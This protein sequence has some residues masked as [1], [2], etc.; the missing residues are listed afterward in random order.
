MLSMLVL[1]AG[2]QFRLLVTTADY[3]VNGDSRLETS[4]HLDVYCRRACDYVF[5]ISEFGIFGRQFVCKVLGIGSFKPTPLEFGRIHCRG[6]QVSRSSTF[7]VI[8]PATSRMFADLTCRDGP[9]K[10]ERSATSQFTPDKNPEAGLYVS[11]LEFVA[12]GLYI[13]GGVCP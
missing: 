12:A 8:T 10:A 5:S 7:N 13:S 9:E 3:G 6:S 1:H 4:I 11:S 2:W